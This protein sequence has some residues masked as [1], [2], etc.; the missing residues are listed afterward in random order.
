MA[1]EAH[2]H[3]WIEAEWNEFRQSIPAGTSEK[4]VAALRAAFFGG[5]VSMHG[6]L[7]HMLWEHSDDEFE[8]FVKCTSAELE[9]FS[10]RLA[11]ETTH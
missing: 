5:S 4:I 3:N 7:L 10:A 9:D 6:G 8:H 11:D 1:H 2:D